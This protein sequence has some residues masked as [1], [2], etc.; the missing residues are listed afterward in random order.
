ME[1]IESTLLLFVYSFTFR[2]GILVLVFEFF[3]IWI[4]ELF[5]LSVLNLKSCFKLQ[6]FKSMHWMQWIRYSIQSFC[7][8]FQ[9]SHFVTT[10]LNSRTYS[11]W[12]HWWLCIC[13]L[14]WYRNYHLI[15]H[16]G[17]GLGFED[18]FVSDPLFAIWIPFWFIFV[19]GVYRIERLLA[20]IFHTQWMRWVY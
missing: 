17:S 3:G 5:F 19:F 9:F 12:W 4:F 18:D 1:R 13:N 14:I 15:C 2:I 6:S 16:W 11:P 20:S 7:G 8:L 10:H